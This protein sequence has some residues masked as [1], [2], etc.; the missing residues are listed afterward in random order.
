MKTTTQRIVPHLW[1][2]KEAIEAAEFYASIFPDSQINYTT[3]L[4]DTPSGDCDVV[5]FE[6]WGHTMMAISAG[7]HFSFTPAIS[8][9]VNFDPLF[10]GGGATGEQTA[11][12]ALDAIWA[13]LSPGGK[14]LMPLDAYPFSPRYG[15]LQDRYGLSWQLILSD[16]GGD[17]RPT[18]VPSL[19]FVGDNCGRAE[20]ALNF[21]QSVFPNSEYGGL[22]RY[23]ADQ[24]PDREGTIMYADVKL[25]DYWL[26]L[27]D[28]AHVHEFGFNEAVSLMIHCDD[29]SEMGY[30][31]Q[32]LSAEPTAERCGWLKDP[33]GVSWQVVPTELDRMMRD[34]S[35]E[36][37]AR[38]TQ[39]S[40][41]MIQLDLAEL[42][43]AFE[44]Q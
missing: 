22:Y 21:Y 38:L 26:A 39:A 28:S 12:E 42:R 37:V 9:M 17:P 30:Y 10:F 6:L 13:S 4:P 34:G 20:E 18:I 11:R 1:Y 27:M 2:D 31:W 16:P 24:L 43:R 29:Q 35:P 5:S 15:W 25:D 33:F 44:G 23:G 14:V 41:Q 7:P 19:L 36:Q 8:F 32:R 40:L 3:T